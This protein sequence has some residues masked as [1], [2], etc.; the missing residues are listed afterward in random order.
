MSTLLP[1][2]SATAMSRPLEP[3][4]AL[5]AVAASMRAAGEAWETIARKVDRSADRVRHWPRLYADEWSHHFRAAET[6][7]LADAATEARQR[8]RTLLRS[9]KEWVALAA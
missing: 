5:I 4:I 8:L 3:P 9:D 2:T 7:M 6:H 1:L